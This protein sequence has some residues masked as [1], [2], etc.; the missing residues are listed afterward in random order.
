MAT[1][2]Q[3]FNKIMIFRINK[4]SAGV[5]LTGQTITQRTLYKP[6]RDLKLSITFNL[7]QQNTV[8]LQ[9][10]SDKIKKRTLVT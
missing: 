7:E 9:P 5:E 3:Q 1:M 2:S 8:K 10:N 6:L 4:L